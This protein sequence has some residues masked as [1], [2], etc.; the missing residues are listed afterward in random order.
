MITEQMIQE[1]LQELRTQLNQL[2]ANVNAFEGAIQDCEFWLAALK[3]NPDAE[4]A[5]KR[6]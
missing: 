6:G 4:N 5:G 2:R 3:E 1:R